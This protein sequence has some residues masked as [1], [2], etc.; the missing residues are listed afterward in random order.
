MQK[1]PTDLPLLQSGRLSHSVYRTHQQILGRFGSKLWTNKMPEGYLKMLAVL[2]PEL[3]ESSKKIRRPT[4]KARTV[5][6]TKNSIRTPPLESAVFAERAAFRNS[7]EHL[8]FTCINSFVLLIFG[9]WYC[10]FGNSNNS[11]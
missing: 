11:S 5:C 3:S 7:S 4:R 6:Q 1:R 8:R 2:V 10:R 9:I